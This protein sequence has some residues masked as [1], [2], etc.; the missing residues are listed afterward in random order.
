MKFIV[1]ILFITVC[2]NSTFCQTRRLD[3]I[4]RL[5]STATSDTARINRINDKLGLLQEV[6]LDSAIALGELNLTSAQKINYAKGEADCRTML[7]S[8]YC[9]KG[10][11]DSAQENLQHA[12]KIYTTI[13]DSAGFLLLYSTYGILY[14][15]Q[16]NYD[17]SIMFFKR[18]AMY[19][20]K[21]HNIKRLNSAYQN[22]ATSYQ[23][24]SN[25]SE[26]LI[27]YQKSLKSSEQLNDI[28]NLAYINLNLGIT[29]AAIG[30]TAKAEQA[31]Y[32][33]IAFAKKNQIKNVQLY[34]YSN[35]ASIYDGLAQTQK[36][37]DY[38]M[39]ANKLGKETGDQG[40]EASSLSR[41]ASELAQMQKIPEAEKMARHAILI[42]DSSQQP[43]NIFQ[44][45]S[46]LGYILKMQGKY[47]EAISHYEKA[48]GAMKAADIYDTQS[49]RTYFNASECYEKTGAYQKA[50]EAYKKYAEIT[51]SVR[52]KQN[53]RKA[54]ELTMNYEFNKKQQAAKA[55]QEKKMKYLKQNKQHLLLG[56]RLCWGLPVLHFMR[57]KIKENLT[58]Y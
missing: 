7:A 32:K 52:S 28:K 18:S 20:D 41:A 53:I 19:A 47:G 24:Q 35:L 16:S 29:Y 33:S 9:F 3:S 39:I 26:A 17:R 48:L 38:A 49:S 58:T 5:I 8:N 22:I 37:Y 34:A 40:M 27:Y 43:L 1:T 55:N 11:Y 46:D 21:L 10:K 57:F 36:A 54:T 44:T 4:N 56:W 2:L 42:A 15:M 23:M 51:D 25:Y 30:D 6:N 12:S 31:L 50:L 45:N 14:G 13:N